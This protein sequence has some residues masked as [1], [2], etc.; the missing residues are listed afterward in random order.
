[1]TSF[2]AE[3]DLKPIIIIIIIISV[4]T[5]GDPDKPTVIV[6]GAFLW[7]AVRLILELDFAVDS[8]E[9][10]VPD[11]APINE[12]T[13]SLKQSVWTF[14]AIKHWQVCLVQSGYATT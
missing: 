2:D 5:K 4:H 1:M 6:R 9:M 14:Q 8:R 7:S 11:T 13:A 3:T 12:S 10:T